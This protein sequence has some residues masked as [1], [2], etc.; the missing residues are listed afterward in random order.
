MDTCIPCLG[1]DGHGGGREV[2]HLLKLEV[3]ALGEHGKFGHVF[4]CASG[5]RADE[6]G[7]ELLME[8]MAAVHLIEDALEV[9]EELEG[10][11]AHEV[12]HT[13]GGVFGGYL[14][15]A[16]HMLGDEFL[17]VLPIDLVGALVT[18]VVEQ[19]VVA[20]A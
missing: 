9:V 8:V 6:V 18:R 16:A 11:L 10:W 20:H 12:E 2:L 15:A 13:L 7:D 4:G 19:E 3:E 1:G 5:M 14:E 17:G